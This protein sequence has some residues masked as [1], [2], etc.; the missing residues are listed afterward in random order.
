MKKWAGFIALALLLCLQTEARAGEQTGIYVAPKFMTGFTGWHGK[1]ELG[2][3]SNMPGTGQGSYSEGAQHANTLVGGALAIGYDFDK[4]YEIPV[5]AEIEYGVWSKLSGETS[6]GTNLDAVFTGTGDAVMAFTGMQFE[7]DI[8]TL[9]ANLYWDFKNS[10]AFTPYV[11][12]GLGLAFIQ[13]RAVVK[14][15]GTNA[16]HAASFSLEK[17][18]GIRGQTNFAWQVGAGCSYAFTDAVSVDLGYR[19][20]SLGNVETNTARVAIEA[21]GST[22]SFSAKGKV[23]NLYMHQVGLGLRITF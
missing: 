22:T 4:K 5:R 23:E 3:S 10:T 13:A 19:F 6:L 8:Q 12:A 20:V 9:M 21:L 1:N 18:T 15:N 14:G 7:M 11:G 17:D 2:V 16:A